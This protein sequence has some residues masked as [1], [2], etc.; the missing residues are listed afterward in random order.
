MRNSKKFK[1]LGKFFFRE[2]TWTVS[3]SLPAVSPLVASPCGPPATSGVSH[4]GLPVAYHSRKTPATYRR[5]ILSA[6]FPPPKKTSACRC[7]GSPRPENAPRR[8]FVRFHSPFSYQPRARLCARPSTI[9]TSTP[10]RSAVHRCTSR[11]AM[12]TVIVGL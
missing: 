10:L 5:T 9:V 8:R 2:K 1:F 3:I 4:A 6:D 11:P 12:G 7:R